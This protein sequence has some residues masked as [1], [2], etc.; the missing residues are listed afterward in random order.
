[1]RVAVALALIGILVAGCA[2]E[3][4]DTASQPERS[5][6]AASISAS[7][8]TPSEKAALEDTASKGSPSAFQTARS[9]RK[10]KVAGSEYGRMLFDNSGQAIYLFDKERTRSPQ[11]YGGCAEAWPP[12]LTKGPPRGVGAV[13]QRLLGTT[14]RKDGSLQVTYNGHP[15]YFYAHEDEN[16]VLCHNVAEFGGLWLV[17]TPSGEPA[18]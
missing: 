9:G 5:S 10:V 2:G 18:T 4:H 6:S 11:C 15:L 7:P 14:R 12:V 8:R 3:S 16:E 13:R 17:V 1:M